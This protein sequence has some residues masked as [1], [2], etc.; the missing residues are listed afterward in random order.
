MRFG[1]ETNTHGLVS[2]ILKVQQEKEADKGK[3]GKRREGM[4][5]RRIRMDED[6]EGREEKKEKEKRREGEEKRGGEE[7]REEDRGG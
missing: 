2:S 7:R 1:L 5:K 3:K 6:G 4:R